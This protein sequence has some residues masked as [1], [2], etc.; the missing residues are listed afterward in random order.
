[1]WRRHSAEP[2]PLP[3][4]QTAKL[5]DHHA[6]L[7]AAPADRLAVGDLIGFGISHPCSA[8]DRWRLIP[9]VDDHWRVVGGAHTFF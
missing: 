7:D 8:F 3:G 9:M 6:F 5:N 1:M 4:T 2:E